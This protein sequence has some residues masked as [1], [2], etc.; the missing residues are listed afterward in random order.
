MVGILLL[1]SFVEVTSV[2]SLYRLEDFVLLA[3]HAPHQHVE[4]HTFILNPIFAASSRFLLREIMRLHGATCIYYKIQYETPIPDVLKEFVQLTPRPQIALPAEISRELAASAAAA[5]EKLGAARPAPFAS[6]A[7]FLVTCKAMSEPKIVNNARIVVLG[8]SDA[9]LALLETLVSV[10]Y[11]H[12]SSLCL[13]A[14]KASQRLRAPR[15][16]FASVADSDETLAA[17]ADSFFA[18]ACSY[19]PVEVAALNLGARVRIIEGRMLDLD[20]QGKAVVM[21]DGSVSSTA[22]IIPP[23]TSPA[24]CN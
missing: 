3:E 19:T 20:R 21:T 6:H 8:S 10:P 22:C 15:G 18:R 12:F 11:L 17:A 5:G 2:Q 9:S 4:L 13:V 1:D 7:L 23:Y 24:P 16:T 14:P